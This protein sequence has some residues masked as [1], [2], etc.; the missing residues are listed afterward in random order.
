[1]LEEDLVPNTPDD[2]RRINAIRML[3]IDAV[4]KAN[5]GHPGLPLG[6]AAAAYVLWSRHLKFNAADTHWFDR[7]R[8]VLSAGHGSML[9]YALLYL[10]GAGLTLDD[11]KNFRQL[12]SKTP[13]HPE[14]HHTPGIEVTTGPL[15]QGISNA[16]GL[17]I[18]EA[19]LAATYN[20]GL[21][22]VDHHTYVLVGDGDLMEGV[23][24]EASSLAGHLKLG[25]LIVL[26]DDNSIS[27]AGPT[28]V[29]FTENVLGRYE[30]YGW[31]A[32]IVDQGDGNDV[33]AI[34]AAINAAKADPR[35]S[36][37]AVRSI[38][39]Y[40]SP[41][42]GSSAA[43]GE[44]LGA[45]NAKKTKEFFGWP[46]EPAFYVP[47]DVLAWWRAVGANGAA[48]QQRWNE[49]VA[50]WKQRDPE[51]AAQFERVLAGTLPEALPWPEFDSANGSVATREAGGTVMNALAAALPE[52]MG[53]S[54]DLDPSTKTYLKGQ[55][56]F[57]PA[58]YDGRNVHFG[59]REHAMGAIA[60][61]L[62][63][64]GGILP[65]TATFFSFVDYMKPAVR[66]A[67]LNGDRVV[68]VF[69]HDSVFVGEDGPTHEPI[70]QLAGLRATP[71]LIVLRPADALET[72]ESWKFAIAHHGPTALVLSRQ[73]VPFLGARQADVARGAYVIHGAEA[74]P[75]VV[76]LA[77]GS[78]VSLAIDAAKL[79]EAQGTAAR[80]VSMPSVELFAR[81][82]AEY[83]DGV[84]PPGVGARVSIEAGSTFGWQRWVGERGVTIGID[85][86][87]ISAPAGAI[88][89]ELGFT[90]ERVAAVAAG[91]LAKA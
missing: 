78:E 28:S 19:H 82:S 9:I 31:H 44:P 48:A 4:Q 18:A 42:E 62:A 83:R 55:G 63:A 75:D 25:K 26:Y 29:S 38:I 36:L 7:D 37:I 74:Q 85:R 61:G 84:L 30:A 54:A 35:P 21:N 90:A 34:D 57:Q 14:V 88:A 16:V 70:E 33:A 72:L 79:L 8:F 76:L 87:G 2:E 77:T 15:G 49:T 60:N 20:R 43:H 58:S 68:F 22:V 81:Q 50:L 41:R 89:K 71:N 69:T 91:L 32:Q 40:G 86:F 65:F 51:R 39:G 1:L 46:L 23:S 10:T 52:L 56:D 27:L 53:G 64:H 24:A 67:A 47:D 17:A 59:V 3:A 6:A 80:V 13:G 45:E 5:S 73:K 12:G 11:L 66:I